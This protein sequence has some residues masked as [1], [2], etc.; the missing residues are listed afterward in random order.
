MTRRADRCPR[1]GRFGPRSQAPEHALAE[2][3][4]R[5]VAPRHRGG[6]QAAPRPAADQVAIPARELLG[7]I[8]L[9]KKAYEPARRQF[10]ELL[11]I[12]RRNFT[13]HY[14]LGWLATLQGNWDTGSRHLQAAIDADPGN[15]AP[16]NALGNLYLRKKELDRAHREFVEAVRLN[17]KDAWAHYNLGVVLRHNNETAQAAAEF[18]KALE[19]DPQFRDASD[20][21]ARLH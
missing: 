21:L 8:L 20:A 1:S 16:H 19:C 2:L 17:P 18:R 13:A 4:G 9:Q 12:A 6:Q 5:A 10:E 3:S 7:R 15:A 11:K 14:N